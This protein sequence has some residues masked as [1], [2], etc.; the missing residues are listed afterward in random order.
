MHDPI[1]SDT[2]RYH[3]EQANLERIHESAEIEVDNMQDKELIEYIKDYPKLTDR[4]YDF[5]MNELKS[6]YEPKI[7]GVPNLLIE[8]FQ[9]ENYLMYFWDLIPEQQKK[10]REMVVEYIYEQKV[11]EME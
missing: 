3:D 2:N 7:F 6:F 11:E 8:L 9:P 4:F 5:I 10:C 1:V